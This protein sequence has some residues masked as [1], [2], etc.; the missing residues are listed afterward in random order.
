MGMSAARRF[1]PALLFLELAAAS[2]AAAKPDP[3]RCLRDLRDRTTRLV[4]E[5]A[6]Q[7]A[8]C[9]RQALRDAETSAQTCLERGAKGVERA[10]ARLHAIEAG[11]CAAAG[12]PDFAYLGPEAGIDTARA[13][14]RGL[15]ADLFGRSLDGS[16]AFLDAAPEAARCQERILRGVLRIHDAYQRQAGQTLRATLRGKGRLAGPDGTP[17]TDAAGLRA[18]ILAHAEAPDRRVD[19]ARERLGSDSERFCSAPSG[20]FPGICGRADTAQALA[21]CAERGVRERFYRTLRAAHGMAMECERLG[22]RLDSLECADSADYA[23]VLGRVAYGADAWTRERILTLGIQGFIEEQ[24]DPASIDDSESE[25]LI[26][27]RFPGSGLGFLALRALY[28]DAEPPL[29]STFSLLREVR[30]AK[31]VR[32]VKSRRQLLQILSDFWF[33]HFNVAATEKSLR[34]DVGP[35]ERDTIRAGALGFFGDLL[36]ATAR[37]PAMARYLNNR[38]NNRNGLNEN[39]AREVMELHTLGVEAGFGEDDVVGLAR[40]LT[41][42]KTEYA[43]PEGFLFSNSQH[44]GLGKQ[45]LELR[46]PAGGGVSDG[47]RALAFLA[48]HP[49]TARHLSRKLVRRFVADDPPDALVDEVAQLFADSNGNLRL[50]TRAIL[51]S[52]EFLVYP[53]YRDNRTKRP[54]VLAISMLRA[55]GADPDPL[56]LNWNFPRDAVDAMG[57]AVFLAQPPTGHPDRSADWTGPGVALL[58]FNLLERAARGSDGVVYDPGV[59][60]DASHPEILGVLIPKLFGRPISDDTVQAA[61]DLLDAL[62]RAGVLHE[63]R[64]KQAAGFLLSSPEFLRH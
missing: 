5:H 9:V 37:S 14:S 56:V 40:A 44:D 46:L 2:P 13:Q 12:R 36:R 4:R 34:Y 35:Y 64:V 3:E 23:H 61:L 26:A 47:E 51:L 52:P 54:F 8:R 42:W 24:L 25:A 27:A 49:S 18:E 15:L 58:R 21:K 50:T 22:L 41:G 16:L 43:E 38:N 57:E 59:P 39:Y 6:K 32:A 1:A 17:V 53:Q 31:F 48:R 20:L 7:Q 10:A 33:N 28:A 60:P 19:R 62:E 63:A 11:S 29:P 45:I 55:L 30:D